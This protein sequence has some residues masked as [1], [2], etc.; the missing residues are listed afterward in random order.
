MTYLRIYQGKFK[1]GEY[2]YNTRTGKKLKPSRLVRMHSNEME[3]IEEAY[4]G[5][6]C[7]VFGIDCASGDSFV[8]DKNLKLTM[9][10]I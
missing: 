6:I 8:T 5:D 2:L 3:D 4:A 10:C 7:A 1:K 9:V